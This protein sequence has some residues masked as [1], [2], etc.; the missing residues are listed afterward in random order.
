MQRSYRYAIFYFG[1]FAL[2]LL[3]SGAVLFIEKLGIDAQS[4]EAFYLG[5]KSAFAQPKTAAGLLETALPHLGAM[6][7]FIFVAGHFF[8]FAAPRTKRA[9]ILPLKLFFAAALLDIASGF[10]IVMGIGIFVFVKLA[11]FLALQFTGLLLLFFL[12]RELLNP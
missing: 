2:A 3:L 10:L 8:L 6:G 11:A 9:M 4:I 7:I 1:V 5:D 12:F